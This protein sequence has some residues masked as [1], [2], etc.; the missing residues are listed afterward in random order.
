M[1]EV[2]Q[3]TLNFTYFKL[4]GYF[5]ASFSRIFSVI[6]SGFGF[7]LGFGFLA[8]NIQSNIPR[9]HLFAFDEKKQYQLV[10]LDRICNLGAIGDDYG[11]S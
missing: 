3:Y 2:F 6:F 1:E 8:F 7:F 11:P 4:R 10:P 5:S 9:F